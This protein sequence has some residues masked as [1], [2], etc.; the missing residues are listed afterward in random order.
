[1][2]FIKTAERVSSLSPSDNYVFQR[3]LLA[4]K[5]AAKYVRGRILEIGTGSGYGIEEIAPN[6]TE[7]WTLD[8]TYVQINY[9]KYTNTRFVKNKVPPLVNIPDNYF[10]FVIC[11]QVIEHIEDSNLLLKEIKRVLRN[12]GLLVISTPN[13][14]MSLTRNPWHVKEFTRNEFNE[15]LFTTFD[16][17]DTKGVFGDE[18]ILTY[19][20]KNKEL[21][22]SILKYDFLDLNKI[23]PS[24]LLKIPYDLMNRFSRISLL[25]SNKK[26]TLGITHENYFLN[27][28]SD[29]CFDLFYVVKKRA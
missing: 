15:F 6:A 18:K 26:L 8:K 2:Y 23:L 5:E 24:C 17:I 20:R 7:F 28:V 25:S 22:H 4:Y 11:F 12:N 10:D 27:D 16:I 9:K 21:V 1:M 29:E 19:Y 3:S 14:K 13:S